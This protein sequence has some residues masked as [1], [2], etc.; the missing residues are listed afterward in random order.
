MN[1]RKAVDFLIDEIEG[2]YHDGR[3]D[4]GGETKW[5][6]SKRSYPD[7]DIPNLTRGRAEDIYYEDF[8]S[9]AQCSQ[10][11]YI[12][13]YSVFDAAVNSGVRRSAKWLQQALNTLGARL[14]VDGRIGPWTLRAVGQYRPQPIVQLMIAHRLK[15][16]TTITR[17]RRSQMKNL[18]G[19]VN[20]MSK[21]LLYLI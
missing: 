13:A 15:F 8:W 7:E 19:W 2:G 10:M 11:P 14:E 18:E 1:F 9:E 17:K 6:I 21:L 3:Y 4:S 16:Y 5:G 20:R 12:V